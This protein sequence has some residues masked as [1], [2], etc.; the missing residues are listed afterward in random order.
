MQSSVDG[1]MDWIY[2]NDIL[3]YGGDIPEVWHWP[4]RHWDEVQSS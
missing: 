1:L 3:T 2:I 4:Q